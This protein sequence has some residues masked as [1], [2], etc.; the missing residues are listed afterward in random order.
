[1][2]SIPLFDLNYGEEEENE[3][4]KKLHDAF[5]PEG[6]K[7][8]PISAVSGK[9]IKELLYYVNDLLKKTEK[10][11]IVFEKEFDADDIMDV[12]NPIVVTKVGENEFSVEGS[13]V[14]R[15]LGYTNLD[16][17]KGF[18][19]FQNFLKTNGI[20]DELER[21]GVQDGDTIKLYDLQFEYYK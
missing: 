18:D 12:Q 8:F 14:A 7:I 11:H 17:E 10:K 2:Y 16:D 20:L 21:L 4:L 13:K 15:M 5:D 19:F 3:A 9:G 1:M 6:I